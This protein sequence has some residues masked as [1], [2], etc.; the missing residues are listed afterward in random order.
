MP[1]RFVTV[2]GL[3]GPM[4]IEVVP[5]EP[6]DIDET[7]FPA[8]SEKIGSMEQVANALGR[9]QSIIDSAAAVSAETLR[10]HRPD[11]FSLEF[12]I[13]F[14]GDAAIPFLASAKADAALTVKIV[15]KNEKSSQS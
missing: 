6:A 12:K 3:D 2:D 10:Q 7:L 8:G 5:A 4:V 9:T 11:E 13:G 14:A 15:W 1:N